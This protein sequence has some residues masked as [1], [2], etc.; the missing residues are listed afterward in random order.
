MRRRIQLA[1]AVAAVA[2]MG[3]GATAAFV[4]PAGGDEPA[5]APRRVDLEHCGRAM[6]D[7]AR[8]CYASDFLAFVSGADDPRAAVATITKAV[9]A[10]G[11]GL[12]ADCHVI[13]HTGVGAADRVHDHVAVGEQAAAAPGS[14]SGRSWT[15][16][17]ATTTRAARPGSRTGS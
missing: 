2:L 1:M 10:R 15:T 17:R 9:R 6:A 3:V 16:C 11:G 12:L 7:E 8:A 5:P 14:P 4:L 13:M